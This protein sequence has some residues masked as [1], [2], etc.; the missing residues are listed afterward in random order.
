LAAQPGGSDGGARSAALRIERPP[1]SFFCAALRARGRE[2]GALTFVR[3][4]GGLPFD[5]LDATTAREFAVRSAFAIENARLYQEAQRSIESRDE[6]LALAGHELK[7]PV[8]PLR[9]QAQGLRRAI[10]R[11]RP[12]PPEQ[13]AERL[14]R[15]DRAAERL[16]RLVD[17]LLEVSELTVGSL[18]LR[19]TR[20]DLR[21]VVARAVERLRDTVERTGSSLTLSGEPAIGVWD[22][23]HVEHACENLLANAAKYGAGNPI[24]MRISSD[25]DV[26][27]LSVT[28]HGVGIPREAQRRLFERFQRP[29]PIQHFGGFGLGLWIVRQVA[30]AHGGKIA[31][32][33]E[34]GVGSRFTLELPRWHLGRG[35][36]AATTVDGG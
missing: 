1:E 31:F 34:P 35:E 28:D 29:A 7:T 24:E 21:D 30:E 19:P 6:F 32:A 13:L 10:E 5:E 15:I 27:R 12:L 18:V 16:E 26:A 17:T 36:A 4:T 2:F 11:A 33:S 23:R 25:A 14:G 9:I 22:A 3:E 20:V 8:T